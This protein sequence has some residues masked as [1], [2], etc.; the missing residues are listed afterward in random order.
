LVLNY[1]DFFGGKISKARKSQVG[2]TVRVCDTKKLKV[3]KTCQNNEVHCKQYS[4][5]HSPTVYWLFRY[6]T[7][8][9]YTNV[10]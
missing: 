1:Y 10:T 4:F 2:R 5:F 6:E 9:I 3:P 8:I 7:A